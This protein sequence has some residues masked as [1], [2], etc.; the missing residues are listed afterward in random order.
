MMRRWISFCSLFI[1]FLIGINTLGY[2][3]GPFAGG[4]KAG[5]GLQLGSP[6][7]VSFD[8]WLNHQSSLDFKV[9]TDFDDDAT[10][11]LDYLYHDFSALRPTY[12]VKRGW[13]NHV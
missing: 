9:G 4:R 3:A 12:G 2:S 13:K 5:L 8:Y 7:G 6:T 11:I 10:F 1:L